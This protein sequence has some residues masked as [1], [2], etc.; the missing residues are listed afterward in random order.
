MNVL[1]LFDGMSCGQIAL[2]RSFVN[3]NNYYASEIDSHAINVT[4]YNYPQ[5]IQLGDVTKIKGSDLPKIDFLIGGSPCQGFSQAGNRLNFDDPRSKLFFDFVRILKETNPKYFLLENVKMKK[6]YEDTITSYMGVEPISI[7][8]NLVS[9]QNRKRLYWTNIPMVDQPKDKG[10]VLKDI[11]EDGLVSLGLAKRTRL[12]DGKSTQNYEL[13]GEEKS[14]ALTTNREH[15]LVFVPI[16]KHSSSDGLICLGG[17]MNPTQKM[18]INRLKID[19][20]ILQRNLCQGYRVYSEN[21][22]AITLSAN[23]G[24][25][26]VKTGLYEIDGVIRK[27]TRIECERLQTVPEGYTKPVS[28]AQAIKMLGNG[29]T[30]DII[31]HIFSYIK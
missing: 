17:L 6:E 7:N 30:V 28:D 9:A 11:V 1:S 23:G 31:S 21:G 19:G 29:W 5:T 18:W 16:D 27:L 4:Q 15:H 14:N 8:S 10:I 25:I 24:G 13:N 12:K 3:Y 26:G 22:K 2:N 20:K